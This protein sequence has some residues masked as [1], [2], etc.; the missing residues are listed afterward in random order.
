ME[1]SFEGPISVFF[2]LFSFSLVYYGFLVRVAYLLVTGLQLQP[3]IHGPQ[4]RGRAWQ[5]SKQW[6]P[7]LGRAWWRL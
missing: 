6:L 4:H 2:A 3:K 5:C 1:V 7:K